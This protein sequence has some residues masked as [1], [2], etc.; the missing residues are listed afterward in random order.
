VEVGAELAVQPQPA[1]VVSGHGGQVV[2]ELVPGVQ[3]R[4]LA[5]LDLAELAVPVLQAPLEV[6][7]SPR[8]APL[9]VV[10]ATHVGRGLGE[11]EGPD[12]GL[13]VRHLL[14][15]CRLGPH[16]QGLGLVT[17]QPHHRIAGICG[18]EELVEARTVQGAAVPLFGRHPDWRGVSF[19][20]GRQGLVGR[21]CPLAQLVGWC[22]RAVALVSGLVRTLGSGLE[23]GHR[24][25]A[26]ADQPPER[27]LRL[28]PLVADLPEHLGVL[29]LFL[30][31]AFSE[32]SPFASHSA[33]PLSPAHPGLR[34]PPWF[35]GG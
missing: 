12:R 14:G 16:R 4:P 3:M 5:R 26:P 25:D 1:V 32:G 21:P 13:N 9:P 35:H 28:T 22:Q 19:W 6:P 11:V 2:G 20:W 34:A 33:S 10:P 29:L 8:V 17:E 18:L 30:S 23:S 15:R 24:R 7:L 31:D 27:L